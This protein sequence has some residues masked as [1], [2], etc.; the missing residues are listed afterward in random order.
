MMHYYQTILFW[1]YAWVLGIGLFGIGDGI[2]Y[3]RKM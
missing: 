1:C 2:Q 3:L